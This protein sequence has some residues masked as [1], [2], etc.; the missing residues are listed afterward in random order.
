MGKPGVTGARDLI[1]AKHSIR[2]G[3]TSIPKHAYAYVDGIT[4]RFA[5][6]LKPFQT[7]PEFEA[8]TD[9]AFLASVLTDLHSLT[10]DRKTFAS[11]SVA[12]Q[13]HLANLTRAFANIG[14]ETP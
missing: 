9:R 12:D 13:L 8:G 6:S 1:I 4:G 5:F 11:L 7:T 2:V 14:M 3:S 10:R